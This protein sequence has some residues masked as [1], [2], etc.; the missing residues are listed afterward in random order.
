MIALGIDPGSHR[1][2]WGLVRQEGSKY[3]L[4]DVG[5][6]KTRAGGP[7][8]ER[9]AQLHGD[10]TALLARNSPDLVGLESVFHGPNT[11]SLVT[12]GQ[13]RGALLAALG[14]FHGPVI[15]LSPAEVKKAV[16]GRGSATKD[17]VAHMMG[18]LLGHVASQKAEE[19]GKQGRYDATDA[20]A[21]AV[22]A[23]QRRSQEQAL[24]QH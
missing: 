17:Q 18:A 16:T 12:L 8:H 20:L 14:V 1:T 22:A 21:V 4:L 11:R 5:L 7:L 3:V 23:L 13:A 6:I 2:G 10:L 9:L 24:A 15:D 19:L